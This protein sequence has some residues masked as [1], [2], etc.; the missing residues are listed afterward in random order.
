MEIE[1]IKPAEKK[2]DC[3]F[4]ITERKREKERKR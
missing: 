2:L 4:K 1:V 3:G